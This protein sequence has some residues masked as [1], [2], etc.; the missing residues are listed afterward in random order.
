MKKPLINLYYSILKRMKKNN[1]N[2]SRINNTFDALLMHDEN[3]KI[4]HIAYE[5]A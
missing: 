3:T 5:K 2:N 1:N 4:Q